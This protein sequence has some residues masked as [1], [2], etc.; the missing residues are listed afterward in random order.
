MAERWSFVSLGEDGVE[1]RQITCILEGK[2][3]TMII[4]IVIFFKH[5]NVKLLCVFT[6]FH[7]K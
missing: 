1:Y 4:Q 2:S 3:I 6:I 7:D 5:R